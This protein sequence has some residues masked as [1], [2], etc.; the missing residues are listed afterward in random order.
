MTLRKKLIGLLVLTMMLSLP[1]LSGT[2]S[3]QDGLLS[4][5]GELSAD[6]CALLQQAGDAMGSLDSA[7]FDISTTMYMFATSDTTDEVEMSFDFAGRVAADFSAFDLLDADASLLEMM[8][9]MEDG[10]MAYGEAMETMQGEFVIT[11]DF[12]EDLGEDAEL[13]DG[14]LE[15][16]IVDGV[17]YL[18]VAEFEDTDV[19]ADWAG[20]DL[21]EFFEEAVAEMD[22]DEMD[23]DELELED[24]AELEAFFDNDFFAYINS[25]EFLAEFVTVERLDDEEVDGQTV[26]VFE[27]TVDYTDALYNRDFQEGLVN[28]M[29]ALAEQDP[30]AG[31]ERGEVELLIFLM[32]SLID[33]AEF[34]TVQWVGVDD[35][36]V[37][38][39]TMDFNFVLDFALLSDFGEDAGELPSS[40]GIEMSVEATMGDFNEPVEVEVPADV[41]MVDPDDAPDLEM[42]NAFDMLDMSLAMP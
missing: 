29:M 20:L 8:M 1:L 17:L 30:D 10:M 2:V 41:E 36:Y 21:G 6:D 33:E 24:L 3:A 22:T 12:P 37:Y 40:L 13:E 11:A 25:D 27:T 16:R 28:W 18:Y 4:Y 5:C 35:H 32:I 19:D 9:M 15:M 7:S 39:S 31:L 23:M 26:A 42:N 38:Y 14:S 34:T